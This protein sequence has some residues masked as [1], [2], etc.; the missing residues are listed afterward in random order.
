MSEISQRKANLDIENPHDY[1]ES[2]LAQ[3]IK[4][5]EACFNDDGEFSLICMTCDLIPIC[6]YN[7]VPFYCS[8][9]VVCC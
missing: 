9:D 3:G 8:L 7:H 2:F 6:H 4:T 1:I 5:G